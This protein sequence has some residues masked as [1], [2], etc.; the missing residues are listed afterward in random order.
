MSEHTQL[1]NQIKKHKEELLSKEI[2][3][4]V[5]ETHIRH[6]RLLYGTKYLWSCRLFKEIIKDKGP[7]LKKLVE[8]EEN[9]SSNEIIQKIKTALIEDIGPSWMFWLE[10][11]T[12]QIKEAIVVLNQIE[13]LQLTYDEESK[14]VTVMEY[15]KSEQPKHTPSP[16]IMEKVGPPIWKDLHNYAK[17]WNGNVEEQSKFLETVK[18][19]IPCGECKTFWVAH[20]HTHPAPT[21]SADAF[22]AWTVEV[23]NKV[24]AK[25]NKPTIDLAEAAN[26]YPAVS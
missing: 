8:S 25:L 10:T 19:R 12:A 6:F 13:K 23:H 20:N 17:T 22:F 11:I 3:N 15:K 7:N 14:T 24:N 18:G 9:S 16:H 4:R 1:L 2:Q 26:L 21:E 5:E